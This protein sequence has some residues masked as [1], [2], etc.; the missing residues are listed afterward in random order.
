MFKILF[1]FI[2]NPYIPIQRKPRVKEIIRLLVI[3]VLLIFPFGL[4]SSI[5][6]KE[7]RITHVEFSKESIWI[8]LYAVFIAPILEEILFR[9]WLKWSKQNITILIVTLIS[10][11]VF[12]FF[13]H[14]FQYSWIMLIMLLIVVALIYLLKN[15]KDEPF[16][17]K[18]FNY[19]YW[20]SSIAFGLVH[21][22]NFTGN[23]WYLIGFSF[24]L[25]S[26]QIL[27]GFILGYIRMNY[28]LRYSILF[29]F[30]INSSLLLSLLHR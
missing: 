21:V 1:R 9:S 4:I 12:S 3:Y 20:I 17:D 2:T 22:S 27:G 19:F 18:H 24:I 13:G 25:G 10:V 8:I 16:I 14:R 23:I 28:G 11:V 30:L 26:P 15:I 29:H 7:L 5:V 6:A